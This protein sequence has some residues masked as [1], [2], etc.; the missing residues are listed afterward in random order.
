[1]RLFIGCGAWLGILIVTGCTSPQER[2]CDID[3]ELKADSARRNYI[4]ET[5]RLAKMQGLSGI[6]GTWQED[7]RR[8]TLR[9]RR[10]PDA[11]EFSGTFALKSAAYG[12]EGLI[13]CVVQGAVRVQDDY[14]REPLALFRVYDKD[15]R[16][17]PAS[18][19]FKN[20]KDPT[21]TVSHESACRDNPDGDY[22]KTTLILPVTLKCG[23]DWDDLQIELIPTRIVPAVRYVVAGRV[24]LN[25]PA[26]NAAT[27]E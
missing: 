12:E 18:L 5:D 2:L 15:K 26:A 10:R 27:K 13:T 4:L 8:T 11:E 3:A 20:M 23:E 6:D 1:M 14:K 22:C 24:S 21:V 9:Y 19:F 25:L 16:R 7:G 17:H